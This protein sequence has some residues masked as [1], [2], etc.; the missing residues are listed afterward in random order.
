M[1]KQVKSACDHIELEHRILKWWEDNQAFEKLRKKNAGNE[2]WSFL[3]GPI[4]ANNPMGVHHAWGR[5]LK[6][7]YQRYH[8][9]L[10]H[11]QRYQNGFDCQGLWVEVEVEKEMGYETKADIERAGLEKFIELCKARVEKYSKVQTNQSIRLG[12]W[13]DWSD[14]YFTMS[15][16]N[17]YTIWTFLKKCHQRGLIY[18][19]MDAMPWCPRCETGISEQER[20][21]GYKNVEDVA[22]FVRFPLQGCEKEYLLIWTTTPWTLAA[23]VAAAVSGDLTYARVRQNGGVYYLAETLLEVLKEKG[24][25]EVE[26]TICGKEMIGWEY[27]GPFDELEIVKRT[28]AEAGYTHRVI[29]WE[30]VSDAE[31]TGIVHIAPGCGKEDFDLGKEL[32]LPV[33]MPL[34][35]AGIYLDGYGFLTGKYAGAVAEEVFESLKGKRVYF[36]HEYYRHDYPHCWRCGTALLFRAVSEW[37]IDMSWRR[38]IMNIVGQIRWI[39]EWGHDQEL[40]WLENMHDWMISKKRF[41]GLALPI[42]ECECGWF[43]V[44]GDQEE[45][46]ERAVEGWERFEGQSPHRPWVDAVRI[47]CDKCGKLTCRITDVGNPWLDAG[48]VPYSTVKYNTDREYWGKW[49]PADLVLEC[50]PGQFRNW[51]YALLAMSTMMEDIPPFRTLLGHALVRDE[52]GKEM[53]K[54]AGNAIWFDEAVEKMGADVMRWI[55]CGHN[56]INNLNFGYKLG[57]QVRRRIFST[58]WNVY[59]FFVNYA[60]LDGFDPQRPAVPH[61]QLQDID[62]WILSKLQAL[63]RLGRESMENYDVAAVVKAAEDFIERL[64]N[65]YVRRNRRRYWRPKSESDQDKLAAYQTLYQVLA[66]LCKIMAPVAPFITEEMYQNLVRSHKTDAPESVHHCDYPQFDDAL[67]TEGLAEEMDLVADVVSRVLSIR[68]I[69]QIRVRQPLQRLIAV[70]TD[71]RQRKVLKRFEPHLLDELN[72]KQLEFVESTDQYVSYNV[73]PNN[74]NLGPKYGKDLNT[75]TELLGRQSA[76]EIAQKVDGGIN[77]TLQAENK[78]WE[79]E[80]QDLIVESDLPGNLV[81]SEGEEPALILDI[82]ITDPLRREGWARDIVRHIQQIRKDIGLEIQNHIKI[83]YQ[84]DDKNLQAACDEYQD[85]IRRETLCDAMAEYDGL[86]S[87]DVKQVKIGGAALKVF[88]QKTS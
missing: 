30:E 53:H 78:T 12:Y 81:L 75:I 66:D 5:T 73:K 25:Y 20:R 58:W 17:N 67:Y 49:V 68:E 56:P 39:P 16:E 29:E 82:A 14:S 60:R 10:G 36:K 3:D 65:W 88:V 80:A 47:K 13:M 77:I 31:G 35:E 44:I 45:L 42:F 27:E 55:F 11:D 74:K 40:N 34:N 62:R 6:D 22:V 41:W 76:A 61:D 37:Y 52:F 8:A 15:D 50:F 85:Y 54:S 18:K 87:T 64:S 63:I 1:F 51:F 21:E 57:D 23:N 48:I 7:C 4:T 59:S 71:E 26:G 2:H 72:I 28:F 43:D 83:D 32:N 24:G 69:K 9:M 33:L 19:G 38:E 79:L 86:T 70:T 84:T 46:K